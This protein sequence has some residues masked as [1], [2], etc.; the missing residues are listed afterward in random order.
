VRTSQARRGFNIK[1]ALVGEKRKKGVA[2]ER[3]MYAQ[4]VHVALLK[5]LQVK[6]KK[7]TYKR[8]RKKFASFELPEEK[9]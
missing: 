1:K 9:R 7:E 8:H 5:A 6:E 3:K 2:S 4:R